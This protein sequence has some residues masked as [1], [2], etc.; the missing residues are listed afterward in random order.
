MRYIGFSGLNKKI[1]FSLRIFILLVHSRY[2]I[3]LKM[4]ISFTI[5]QLNG[6]LP[7]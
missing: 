6:K 2:Y 4:T 5:T 3:R 7:N 1:G